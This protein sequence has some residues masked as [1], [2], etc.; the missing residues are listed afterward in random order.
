MSD[1][2]EPVGR[3]D[4]KSR[5]DKFLRDLIAERITMQG[6]IDR[7]QHALDKGTHV[8]HHAN[9][10]RNLKGRLRGID[11]SIGI[12]KFRV[13]HPLFGEYTHRI[14]VTEVRKKIGV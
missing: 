5:C 2:E 7:E 13:Y 10:I 12:F 14:N 9:T 6:K 11:S 8:I 4:L 3:K 1:Q